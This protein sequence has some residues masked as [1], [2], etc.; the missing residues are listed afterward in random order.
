[1]RCCFQ[2]LSASAPRTLTQRPV[3]TIS[4]HERGPRELS[5]GWL[6]RSC[7]RGRAARLGDA[8][9]RLLHAPR[10]RALLGNDEGFVLSA[11]GL[12]AQGG[13]SRV[14]GLLYS[15]ITK[16]RL[17]ATARVPGSAGALGSELTMLSTLIST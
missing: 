1:V 2:R 4:N 15:S 5:L 8:A 9:G 6:R 3:A 10:H 11:E 12:D 7:P 17:P 16:E 13:T 14:Y